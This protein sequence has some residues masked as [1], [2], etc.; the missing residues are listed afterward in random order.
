MD[1][2]DKMR[3]GLKAME[4]KIELPMDAAFYDKLHDKIMARVESAEMAPKARLDGTKRFLKGH[5]RSWVYPTGSTLALAIVGTLL[6]MQFSSSGSL[7][8]QGPRIQ[9]LN[10]TNEKVVSA[11]LESPNAIS[12]TLLSSQTEA[13]FFVD[14]ASL[15]FENL[16]IAQFNKIM[17]EV[18]R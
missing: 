18:R 13:D 5:W 9:A 8:G 2:L 4:E 17:G 14:V 7:N 3:K 12:Q 16:N 1:T 10:Q 11:A 15:S 6:T